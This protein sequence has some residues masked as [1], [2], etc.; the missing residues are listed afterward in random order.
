MSELKDFTPALKQGIQIVT[1]EIADG[2]I[3]A[4]KIADGTVVE[5][6]IADDAVTTAKIVDSAVTNAKLGGARIVTLQETFAL[7]D[8]TDNEDTTGTAEF[9][10]D[11]P[12]GAVVMQTLITGVTGFI[13][14]TSATITIGDGS[15][16]DRYNTGTPSVFTTVANLSAGAVSGTAFQ[17]AAKTPTLIVTTNADFTS[18]TAGALT[19]TIFYYI[20]A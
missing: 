4:A 20:A 5:A 15:D 1:D 11:I 9:A 19:V 3:T 10:T 16:V 2:A 12:I 8:F 17:T 7:T 14:D 13:G 6:D 18:V